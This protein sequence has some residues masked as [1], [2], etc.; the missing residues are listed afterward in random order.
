M[1]CS[2]LVHVVQQYKLMLYVWTIIRMADLRTPEEL[3]RLLIS[4]SPLKTCQLKLLLWR[5]SLLLS[6][7]QNTGLECSDAV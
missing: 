3:R 1:G 4:D 7:K 6:C 5:P 2:T